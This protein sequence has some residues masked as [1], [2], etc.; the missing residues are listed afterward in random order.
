LG[1]GGSASECRREKKTQIHGFDKI[2][3]LEGD[4]EYENVT[5]RRPPWHARAMPKLIF[6]NGDVYEGDVKDG[7]PDGL[8]SYTSADG[9]Q[10]DGEFRNG[11]KEGLGT[12]FWANG[13][14]YSG[15]WR[16]DKKN[17]NGNYWPDRSRSYYQGL[18]KNDKYF[19]GAYRCAGGE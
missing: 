17:G 4:F 19:R 18:W 15:E 3:R 7:K 6:K 12:M 9:S 8:G 16:E 1:V 5:Q 13:E 11:K 14:K 2:D 10:Y